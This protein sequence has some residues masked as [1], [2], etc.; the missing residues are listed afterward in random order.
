ME[1][2]QEPA[3]HRSGL[4]VPLRRELKIKNARADGYMPRKHSSLRHLE[5]GLPSAANGRKIMKAIISFND[6][7]RKAVV[8]CTASDDTA[9]EAMRKY[10]K[11]RLIQMSG[12]W[13]DEAEKTISAEN[14]ELVRFNED[15]GEA[16][17]YMYDGCWETVQIIDTLKSTGN[18]FPEKFAEGIIADKNE[19]GYVEGYVKVNE[20]DMPKFNEDEDF[21]D[22]IGKK[23]VGGNR[24]DCVEYAIVGMESE[25]TFVLYV[26]GEPI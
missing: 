10:V 26:L 13:E 5:T 20:K 16:S 9:K 15:D 23:L 12:M 19:Y 25:D 17:L 1:R 21:L 22:M 8:I 7:D 3:V 4:E 14:R 6:E 24:L 2:E 11:A 18:M